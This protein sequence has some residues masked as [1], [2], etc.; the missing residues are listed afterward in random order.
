MDWKALLVSEDAIV[1][2]V[3]CWRATGCPSQDLLVPMEEVE[4]EGRGFAVD[5][6][7]RRWPAAR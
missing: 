5:D 7:I 4:E 2:S 6:K 3:L 1:P